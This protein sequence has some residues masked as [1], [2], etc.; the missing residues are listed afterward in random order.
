MAGKDTEVFLGKDLAHARSFG[1]DMAT[2]IDREVKSIMEECYNKAK[3][4]IMENMGVL[5]A[6]A[7]LLMDK[8][9]ITRDE[10]ESLFEAT[11]PQA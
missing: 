5:H 11:E 3:K 9:K 1:E 8:E 6:S 10:F 7:N 2:E 4:I